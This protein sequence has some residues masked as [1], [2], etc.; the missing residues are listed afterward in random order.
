MENVAPTVEVETP[1]EMADGYYYDPGTWLFS[2]IPMLF[3][4]FGILQDESELLADNLRRL[5]PWL[6]A[7][8]LLGVAGGF[9]ARLF[10]PVGVDARASARRR[11][12]RTENGGGHVARLG[13]AL[14]A[15]RRARDLCHPTRQL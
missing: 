6:I 4:C 14:A 7:A 2:P 1:Y 10:E 15:D 3:L 8:T 5:W 13:R 11:V 12:D 9:A